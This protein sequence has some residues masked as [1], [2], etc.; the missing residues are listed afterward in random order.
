MKKTKLLYW[1]IAV[2]ML[3]AMPTFATDGGVTDPSD[4]NY[5]NG[6]KSD[7]ME[8]I[9]NEGNFTMIFDD[10][11]LVQ[12]GSPYTFPLSIG[13]GDYEIWGIGGSRISD[14]NV[15]VYDK[16]G[17]LTE[18]GDLVAEDSQAGNNPVVR[19]SAKGCTAYSVQVEGNGFEPG[20]SEGYFLVIVLKD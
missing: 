17:D 11:Q 16:H 19:F 1:G 3:I 12:A 7:Y 8:R 13:D 5:I 6:V 20:F 10:I 4:L 9:T 15:K 2:L 18:Y 14:L